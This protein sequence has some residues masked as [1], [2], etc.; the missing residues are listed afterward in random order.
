MTKPDNAGAIIKKIEPVK[1]L[2]EELATI[3]TKR[4]TV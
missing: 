1:Y 4:R 3:R 2:Q